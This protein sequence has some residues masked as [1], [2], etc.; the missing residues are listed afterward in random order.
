MSNSET[1]KV[2]LCQSVSYPGG[3]LYL[4]PLAGLWVVLS[5]LGLAQQVWE[6]KGLEGA[7]AGRT[8]VAERV[9]HPEVSAIA[10]RAQG[11]RAQAPRRVQAV[12]TNHGPWG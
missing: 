12:D 6:H 7:R 10:D 4:L 11:A 3:T 2:V 1:Q 5:I 9:N 8:G